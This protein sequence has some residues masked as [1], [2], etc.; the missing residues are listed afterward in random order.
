LFYHATARPEARGQ[1]PEA[2]LESRI[3]NSNIFGEEILLL[4]SFRVREKEKRERGTRHKQ[5][6]TSKK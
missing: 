3:V 5:G 1:R 4:F 2:R 6:T